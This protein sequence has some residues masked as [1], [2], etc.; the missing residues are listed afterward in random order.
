MQYDERFALLIKCANINT[1]IGGWSN[2]DPKN[3]TEESNES[4]KSPTGTLGQPA[5]ILEY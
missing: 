4:N 5:S 2:D 3:R 1:E